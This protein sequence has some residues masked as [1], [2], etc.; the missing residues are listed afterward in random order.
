[1]YMWLLT[2]LTVALLAFADKAIAGKHEINADLN[3][4]LHLQSKSEVVLESEYTVIDLPSISINDFTPP[5]PLTSTISN[6]WLQGNHSLVASAS[7]STQPIKSIIEREIPA[8]WRLTIGASTS[9]QVVR[10]RVYV[11]GSTGQEGILV[12]ADDA[13]EGLPVF[14]LERPPLRIVDK[15]GITSMRGGVVLQILTSSLR[16][17]G[18]YSGRIVISSEGF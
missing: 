7:P 3:K 4:A 13:R 8:L 18:R 11:E 9:T 5:T 6:V 1:M 14:V 2:L 10:V 15:D 17:A 16:R 12:S